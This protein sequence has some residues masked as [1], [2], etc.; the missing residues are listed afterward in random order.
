MKE[1][2]ER[3]MKENWIRL[4]GMVDVHVHLRVPGGQHKEDFRTGTAAALAGGVT[5][6]LAMPNTTPPLT[7]LETWQRYQSQAGFEELCPVYLYCGATRETLAQLPR[8]GRAAKA[9][10]IYL[11]PTYGQMKVDN[12]E[13]LLRIAQAWPRDK[14]LAL[15]AEG[16]HIRMGIRVAE[17]AERP[18]HFCHV[19]RKDEIEWIAMAKRDGLPVTCE[20][21]PHHLF[22]TEVDAQRLG[23]LGDMRPRLAAQRDVEGLWER[24]DDTIDIIAT[25]HAPHTLAEKAAVQNPPPGVPGLESALPLMLT[26]VSQGR[27]SM[28]RLT[29][30]MH[31]NPRRIFKL[32]EQADTWV[33]VDPQESYTFPDHPLYS[34]CGWSPF[35]GRQ[36]TGRIK[37]VVLNGR[38]IVRDGIIQ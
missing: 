9:L 13:D 17:K 2:E 19:S 27:L 14:V 26:A 34:K 36:M 5:Q 6:M 3:M 24:I 21:T 10:K 38:E 20:V 29:A 4:P 23:N 7:D 35:N 37:R 32:P 30:L 16:D 1:I 12:E 11:D 8:L 33:E 22:L 25:D 15:H 31:E 28:A 18:V